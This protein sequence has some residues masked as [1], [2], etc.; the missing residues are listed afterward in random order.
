M[1]LASSIRIDAVEYRIYDVHV[2]HE[3]RWNLALQNLKEDFG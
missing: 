3:R 1:H 2:R